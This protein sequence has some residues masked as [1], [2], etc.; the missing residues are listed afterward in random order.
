MRGERKLNGSEYSFRYE[1]LSI[2]MRFHFRLNS[3]NFIS[4]ER[5]VV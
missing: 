4:G 1:M 5:N 2:Y 3:G